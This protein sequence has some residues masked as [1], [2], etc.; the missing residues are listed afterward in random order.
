M[1]SSRVLIV[2]DDACIRSLLG[3]VASRGRH[4]VVCVGDGEAALRELGCGQ[5]DA[6]MLDL[7]LPRRNGFE[8]IRHMKCTQPA[9]LARTIVITAASEATL[10][11]SNDEL[12]LVRSVF[13]KPVEMNLL[14]E[15]VRACTT[16][17]RKTRAGNSSSGD[18]D[19]RAGPRGTTATAAR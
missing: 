17:A 6:V 3:V 7:L 19:E 1:A 11:S 12:R 5:F 8:V 10:Q 18:S 4:S 15:E 16:L 13:R 14:I 9:M 2:E